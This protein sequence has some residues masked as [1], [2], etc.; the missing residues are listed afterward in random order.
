MLAP[1]VN[2]HMADGVPGEGTEGH[3][4]ALSGSTPSGS[5][6]TRYHQTETAGQDEENS[7]N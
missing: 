5:P 6:A 4:S 3:D 7:M 1:W 2:Q